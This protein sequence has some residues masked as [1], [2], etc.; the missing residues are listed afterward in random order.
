MAISDPVCGNTNSSSY[1]SMFEKLHRS[2]KRLSKCILLISLCGYLFSQVAVVDA[3]GSI[4]TTPAGKDSDGDDGHCVWYDQCNKDSMGKVQNCVYNGTAKPL[5]DKDGL[6][7][8][9]KWCP[10][11]LESVG[12]ALGAKTCCNTKMLLS[13]DQSV[14]LAAGFLKRCPSCMQNLV[15]HICHLTC[16]P[17]QSDF[18]NV[19]GVETNK[20]GDEYITAIDIY[21]SE[22]YTSGTFNSCI[23]VSVPSTGQLALD[24]M[25][26]DWGASRCSPHK[27]FQYM[28]DEDGNPYVP[29]QMT[30]I[31][32]NDK[33]DGFI[34]LDPHVTPCNQAVDDK[35]PACSCVDCEGSCPAPP[36]PA[37][38]PEPWTIFGEDGYTVAAA[39]LF[40]IVSTAFLLAVL[41]F[42]GNGESLA[43]LVRRHRAEEVGHAVGQRLAA[44]LSQSRSVAPDDEEASPLQSKRSSV[45]SGD[46]SKFRS[47][48]G[49]GMSGASSGEGPNTSSLGS[50]GH[51]SIL[52]RMGA[53]M[54]RLL[55]DSFQAWGTVC[56]QNPWPVL[57]FGLCVI[58]ALG[59]G[60]KYMHVTTDPVELWASPTSRARQE[61]TYFDSHFE[62]FYRT[63]QVIITAKNL[64]NIVH[65]TSNGPIEFGPVFHKKFMEEVLKL[66]N[67]IEELGQAEGNGLDAVCFAPLTSPVNG[68]S[69][70]AADVSQCV[71]QSVWGYF[72]NDMDVFTSTTTD[73]EGYEVNYLDHLKSCF[74]NSYNP[75]CLAP[76]GGPV[77]PSIAVGGFLSK[78]N[79][80]DGPAA[81]PKLETAT[82]IILTFLVNN[83]HNKTKLI[84]A[85]QW[86]S[87]FVN[88][89]KNWTTHE[90]PSFM[91]VAFTSERSIEDELER[92]SQSDV[93]TILVSYLIMFAY[94]AIALGQFRNCRQLLVDSKVTLGLGGVLI[95]LASVSSSVGLFGFIGVPATLIIIEVIPFLVLAVGVDNIFILVQTHQ[96]EVRR[97]NESHAEHIGR[98]LG[99]VGPSML[100]TSLSEICCFFLG[101]LSD[102]PAVRAFALY[103]GM[104]LLLDFLLQITCFVALLSLDVKR[105]AA[106]RL[107]VCCF[108]RGSKSPSQMATSNGGSGMAPGSEGL[109]YRF[110]QS[111]YAPWLMKRWVRAGVMVVFFGWL[112]ASLAVLPKIEVGLDQ[113]LSMPEDSYVLKYFK[114]LKDY[115]SI[116]PPMYFVVTDGDRIEPYG[117][118]LNYSLDKVQ[119]IMCGGQFCNSDSL[120]TQIYTASKRPDSTYIAR[121]ASSWLDD[122]FDWSAASGCCKYHPENGSFCPHQNYGC[123]ECNIRL[124]KENRPNATGFRHYLPFFLQ[125]NPS[126]DCAKAGHAAYGQGVKYH[127]DKKGL[128][129]VGATYYMAYHSV[130]KTSEDYYE[131]LRS[132]RDISAKITTMM[133]ERLGPDAPSGVEVFPYSIFYVFYEQYLTMWPDT[134]QS[135]GIS[136]AAIFL[137]TFV[138]MGMDIASSFVVVVTIA[139]IVIDIGG[140]MYWWGI[141]LNAVS[142]VNLVMTVGIAV[143]FC[144]HLVHSFAVSTEETR[145]GRAMD[146]LINMGTSVF[147]GI[148]LTKFGGIVVLG[149]AK[150]QIF[151]VFYF[152]MYLG[153]VLFGAAH[154]LIFLP[155]FLSYVGG[156][157][158][159][160]FIEQ[161]EEGEAGEGPPEDGVK[162]GNGLPRV[163]KVSTASGSYAS[164]SGMRGSFDGD[165]EDQNDH[166]EG[167]EKTG[168]LQPEGTGYS[169]PPSSSSL[170]SVSGAA[171]N[172]SWSSLP[173]PPVRQSSPQEVGVFDSAVFEPEPADG[174]PANRER[175]AMSLQRRPQQNGLTSSLQ[176]TRPHRPMV[177][178]SPLSSSA[179]LAAR[180][181]GSGSAVSES[182]MME[183]RFRP[184]REEEK[185][186][187]V[188][189]A[190]PTGVALAHNAKR[191]GSSLASA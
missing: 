30:Y 61:R 28:G 49:E 116:G 50:R 24:I 145:V 131:A 157:S 162:G 191:K 107:D 158:R 100:L 129:S 130:L 47:R 169:A 84:P 73:S 148:T 181:A 36:P 19:T 53:S 71:V 56:A 167:G 18:I 16:S 59:H 15:S 128:A 102:M 103:A 187:V 125:D 179:A 170:A 110:F 186:E 93:L 58:V 51:P 184:R 2:S 173:L 27:W 62:P 43:S 55:E 108:I 120:S 20:N 171:A 133:R 21:V 122:Y 118:G 31:E 69:G 10:D 29:F 135:M 177:G 144:S 153:I 140:L 83:Y 146:S 6:A 134:L 17:Y 160:M 182:V 90:K 40:V 76:Y 101:A 112:C 121:P 72:Q 41:C 3:A 38:R 156:E 81:Q 26:G 9:Q 52:E 64:P 13:L 150:S 66:Q 104:A 45:V 123:N 151:Q 7:V 82:A 163:N 168:E 175:L 14:N 67:Q 188:D 174:S 119:N 138:L 78:H 164:G 115:L 75:V 165:D 12:G 143:E 142:L 136:L 34:P 1:C 127:V 5:T 99:Q 154:G 89:M 74:Q 33:K 35:T 159:L 147:S 155:V 57:F 86:E 92:E 70:R 46:G 141:S 95:V 189:G 96:R 166:E 98:T 88:F 111:V 48:N 65:N 11:F 185:A 87:R 23:Q 124:N 54:D 137:V 161:N 106:N 149:F 44:G 25:C 32:T 37:P 79:A 60:I 77:E 139:A 190:L 97:P 132:A 39:L 85:L 63:Q 180:L 80:A 8:L 42:S 183:G 91:D 109:L 68:N 172:S 152:R 105:Q 113:E 4:S 117:P 94:I 22:M 176:R 126:E 114:F 178:A